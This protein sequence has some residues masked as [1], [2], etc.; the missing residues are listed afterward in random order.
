MSTVLLLLQDRVQ[1]RQ[2][3]AKS[4]ECDLGARTDV[5]LAAAAE[6]CEAESLRGQ[7]AAET[8]A[9]AAAVASHIGDATRRSR[10]H[11]VETRRAQDR[12]FK[13]S[14]LRDMHTRGLVM[15]GDRAALE[16]AKCR[17]H[18]F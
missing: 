13:A 8:T 12:A 18:C 17:K 1:A 16:P 10:A 7:A 9:A 4:A 6:S 11:E 5:N 15:G 3:E 14:T 2:D